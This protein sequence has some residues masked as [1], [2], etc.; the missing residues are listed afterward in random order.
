MLL[1]KNRSQ[2]PM[3]LLGRRSWRQVPA[4]TSSCGE[5]QSRAAASLVARTYHASI[6]AGFSRAILTLESENRSS[7]QYASLA[8]QLVCSV[9]PGNVRSNQNEGTHRGGLLET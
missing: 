6:F 3:N 1:Q 9:N 7:T 4:G 2:R 5:G 8:N